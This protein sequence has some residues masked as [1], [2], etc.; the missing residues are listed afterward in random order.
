MLDCSTP[1]SGVRNVHDAQ[2]V[3]GEESGH[4][5]LLS[6]DYFAMSICDIDSTSDDAA[7]DD[8]FCAA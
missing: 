6:T 5:L 7:A 2:T 4:I 8:D 1:A 3:S